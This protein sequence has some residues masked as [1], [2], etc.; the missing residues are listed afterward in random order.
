MK[1][2]IF[3]HYL[4][5]LKYNTGKN[6]RNNLFNFIIFEQ[7]QFFLKIKENISV[8]HITYELCDCAEI[9]FFNEKKKNLKYIL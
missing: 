1:E 6:L 2:M 7:R 3:L 8:S 4:F 9:Y 5:R